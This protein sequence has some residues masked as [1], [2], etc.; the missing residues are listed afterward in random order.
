M[1]PRAVAKGS[2]RLIPILT[3]QQE[4]LNVILHSLISFEGISRQKHDLLWGYQR[5]K[6]GV[7]RL[8]F[9]R[10]FQG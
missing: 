2:E 7:C 1:K 3:D 6:D 10:S 5:Q 8:V 4:L 9:C